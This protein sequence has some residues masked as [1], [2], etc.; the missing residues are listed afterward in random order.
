[1]TEQNLP[2]AVEGTPQPAKT[3]VG[4]GWLKGNA[5]IIVVVLTGLVNLIVTLVGVTWFLSSQISDLRIET[6]ERD[7]LSRQETNDRISNLELQMNENF[8]IQAEMFNQQ[9][10]EIKIELGKLNVKVDNL[11][12]RMASL[13]DR[14]ASIT[15]PLN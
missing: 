11:D 5:P 12:V 4:W 14:M 8:R 7:S 2:K 15:K 6:I 10:T 1:M 3:P 9:L 13:E